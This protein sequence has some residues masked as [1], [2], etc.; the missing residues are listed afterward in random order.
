VTISERIKK[1]K[2]N[3]LNGKQRIIYLPLDETCGT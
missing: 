1:N 2:K 3:K